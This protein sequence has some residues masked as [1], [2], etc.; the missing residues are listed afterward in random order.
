MQPVRDQCRRADLAAGADPVSGRQLVTGEPGQ[1][2]RGH[3]DEMATRDADA[4]AGSPPHRRPAPRMPRWPGRPP[5]RPGLRP[6]RS[7]RCTGG[8]AA[9]TTVNATP[10]GTAVSASAAL[11]S[12]SPSSPTDPDSTATTAW[13]SA[14]GP[15]R[16]ARSTAPACPP[17]WLPSRRPPGRPPHAN[18]AQHMPQPAAGPDPECSCLL[19]LMRVVM[20]VLRV[21]QSPG[22]PGNPVAAPRPQRSPRTCDQ[23]AGY[24]T[25][26]DLVQANAVQANAVQADPVQA[27]RQIAFELE[28]AA[29]RPTGCRRSAVPRGWPRASR[30]A[31]S[32]AGWRRDTAGPAWDRRDHRPGHSRGRGAQPAT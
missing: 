28:R 24:E 31:S 25:H 15:A 19:V 2:G 12:V 4:A 5:S 23:V 30:R 29:R 8:S 3:R 26:M 27:L 11:C 9:G 20:G 10:S 17:R 16:P 22:W 18:A 13:I 7:R 14:V 21:T 32:S 6:A 1:G